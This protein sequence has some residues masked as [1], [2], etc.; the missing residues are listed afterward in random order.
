[1]APGTLMIITFALATLINKPY[2]QDKV[3]KTNPRQPGD[4]PCLSI[5]IRWSDK[6]NGRGKIPIE[7]FLPYVETFVREGG[8]SIF[9]ATDQTTVFD[10]ID[11]QWPS[12]IKSIIRRQEGAFLSKNNVAVFRQADHHRSNVE[13]ITEIYALS[14]CS[15]LLHGLSAMTEAA[16]FLNIGLHDHSV[17][18][19]DPAHPSVDEFRTMVRIVQLTES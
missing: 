5:H 19:D 13:A 7:R 17:N 12:N 18:M 11:E 6:G 3:D 10:R 4:P 2:I 1:M 8:Q 14:K 9:L 15:L 16:M